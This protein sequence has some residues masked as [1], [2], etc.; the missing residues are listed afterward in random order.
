VTTVMVVA[1]EAVVL[2]ELLEQFAVPASHTWY[3]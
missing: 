2:L 1:N 3:V